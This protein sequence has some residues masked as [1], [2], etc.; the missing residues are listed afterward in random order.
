VLREGIGYLPELSSD[1][2]VA[3]LVRQAASDPKVSVQ[4][5]T[6]A[7]ESMGSRGVDILFS[8]WADTSRRT[9]A[10]ALSQRYLD[11]EKV[12][13][14]ASAALKIALAFRDDSQDCQAVRSLVE[15]ALEDGDSRATR[16]MARLRNKRGCGKGRSQD[17]YACLRSDKLLENALRNV[18]QR[19]GPKY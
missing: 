13:Q 4:A 9:P 8:V 17:C 11:E 3:L 18:L 6:L 5:V 12:R 10:T 19:P 7:A 14:K 2:R 1:E 15:K 16:P